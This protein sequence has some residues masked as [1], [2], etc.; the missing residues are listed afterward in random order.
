MKATAHLALGGQSLNLFPS[1]PGDRAML[2]AHQASATGQLPQGY[3]LRMNSVWGQ[4]VVA[5]TWQCEHTQRHRTLHI[6]G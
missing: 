2:G 5:V 4:M 3:K 1:N 6:T